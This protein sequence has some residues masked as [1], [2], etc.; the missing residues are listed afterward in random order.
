ME[1]I[2]PESLS[3]AVNLID[4]L[5]EAEFN[6]LAGGTDLVVNMKNAKVNPQVIIDISKLNELKKISIDDDNIT[7]GSL[8][9][10][11]DLL[12]CKELKEKIPIISSAIK[13]VGSQQIRNKATIGGNIANASPGGDL[14]T[15]LSVL[16]AKLVLINKFSSR[17][18]DIHDFIVG[19]NKTSLGKN[20]LLTAI[21]FKVPK[22]THMSFKKVGRRN[23]LAITL[24]NGACL[25]EKQAEKVSGINLT[26]GAVL[27]R[28]HRFSNIEAFLIGKNLNEENLE[29][30]GK[31]AKEFIFANVDPKDFAR[32][33][34]CY[35]YKMAVIEQFTKNLLADAWIGD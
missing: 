19:P 5:L 34:L 4:S 31:L 29:K 7:I 17:E 9:T 12:N 10:L 25:I 14:I 24:M 20:E 16:N 27:A 35:D 23:A 8:V 26:L 22:R 33:E 2:Q 28:P 15:F 32:K 18:I 3:L 13:S 6:I 21:K 11:T 30:A 1:I